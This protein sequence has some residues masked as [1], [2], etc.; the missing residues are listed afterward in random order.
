MCLYV[1]TI[2][3][4]IGI[5][6]SGAAASI[7]DMVSE[8]PRRFICHCVVTTNIYRPGNFHCDI[9]NEDRNLMFFP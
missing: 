1:E 4:S 7:G 8:V 9:E 3:A 5:F 6:F 2:W